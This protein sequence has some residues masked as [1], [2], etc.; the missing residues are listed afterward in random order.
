[1]NVIN[2]KDYSL[3]RLEH[4]FRYFKMLVFMDFPLPLG[5]RLG[6]T[7]CAVPPDWGYH[8]HLSVLVGKDHEFSPVDHRL[9]FTFIRRLD[10]YYH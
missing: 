9:L 1:M 2:R 5:S 10:R 3:I 4:L 6:Q 7:D 8:Q